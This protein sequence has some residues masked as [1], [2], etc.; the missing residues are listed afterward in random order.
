MK[1]GKEI[2]H[3]LRGTALEMAV[4][5]LLEPYVG[6]EVARAIARGMA[7]GLDIAASTKEK[8][9]GQQ[10]GITDDNDSGEFLGELKRMVKSGDKK[11]GNTILYKLDSNTTIR[12]C[13]DVGEYAH[14]IGKA[15]Y[16]KNTP[17]INIEVME[18]VGKHKKIRFNLH[19]ILDEAGR[20][21]DLFEDH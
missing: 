20:I 7:T 15:G 21:I 9:I 12:F 5:A 11:G 3:Q 17:H 8:A 1:I 6:P 18:D 16:P 4:T 10:W 2:I 13:N 14:P 19:I